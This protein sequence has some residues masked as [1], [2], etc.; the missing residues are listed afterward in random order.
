MDLATS[1]S[2][3]RLNSSILNDTNSAITA[4]M[5][6]V[7]LK[8]EVRRDFFCILI[9]IVFV[10]DKPNLEEEFRDNSRVRRTKYLTGNFL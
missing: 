3:E 1:V 4:S 6:L 9:E 2:S 8:G 5:E 7:L 10:S